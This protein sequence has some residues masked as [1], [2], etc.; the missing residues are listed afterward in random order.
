MATASRGP[1]ISATIPGTVRRVP[2]MAPPFGARLGFGAVF[3]FVGLWGIWQWAFWLPRR[4]THW[5]HFH[6]ARP[7]LLTC[8]PDTRT[9]FGQFLPQRPLLI[10]S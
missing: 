3:V 9:L 1:R 5:V 7:A 8:F 10:R 6:V 4:S 2:W